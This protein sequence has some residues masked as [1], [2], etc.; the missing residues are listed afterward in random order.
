MIQRASIVVL[1]A[2]GAIVGAVRAQDAPP[3]LPAPG[4]DG[5]I[6][7]FD[8]RTLANWEG[9]EGFWEVRDGA[10]VGSSTKEKPAPQTFLVLS[11]SRA[12]PQRF[13]NFELHLKYRFG[14]PTGNSG[15]QFRSRLLDAKTFRVGGYQ[16][17][18]DAEARYDG[19]IYDE[20]NVAGGRGTMSNRGAK[21]TWNADNKRINENLESDNAALR[22]H[23][24]RGEW[25][26][27]VIVANGNR[28]TYT[29]NGH[30][31][32]DLTDD[33]PRALKDGLIALQLHSGVVME[34]QFKDIRIKLGG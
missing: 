5:F 30:L 8:G 32:T 31:M 28:I 9:L 16:G 10:I 11:A 23:I 13:G 33:S 22:A 34:I 24:R 26:E 29:I 3:A 12:E 1:L 15:V 14:T 2:M 6:T 20:A 19:T 27:A 4:A 25:N 7:L 21:T 18:M 17:D